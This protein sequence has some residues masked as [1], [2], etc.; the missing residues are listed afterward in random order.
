MPRISAESVAA[1]VA[2][3]EAAVLDAAVRLFSE[4]GYS[5]VTIGDIAA[6]VGL[7]RNSLY[8]YFPDKDHILLAWFRRELPGQVR[9]SH[10]LLR[11]AGPPAD[12]IVA[13]VFAQMD[14]AGQPAHELVTALSD[15]ARHLDPES[16]RE[17]VESRARLTAPLGE[18]LREAGLSG[19]DAEAAAALI[20]G[21]VAAAVRHEA[22]G[23]DSGAVRDR[24]RAAVRVL[25]T[26]GPTRSAR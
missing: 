5:E 26:A 1:H 18:A 14:D 3:Q 13:W 8:R 7:A 4:R 2:R 6:E 25:A 22:Q 19:G 24:L 15:R 21:L 11:G 16:R 12:R 17:L 23:G 10:E 9:R 20:D